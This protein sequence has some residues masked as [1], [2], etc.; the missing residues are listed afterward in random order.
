MNSTYSGFYSGTDNTII[1]AAAIPN[2]D[3][4][5]NLNLFHHIINSDIP[6]ETKDKL[7]NICNDWA[8]DVGAC[9]I[10][11]HR[12]REK[13]AGEDKFI[14]SSMCK[15][16][17]E[18]FVNYIIEEFYELGKMIEKRNPN[19]NTIMQIYNILFLIADGKISVNDARRFFK[20]IK[21]G[22]SFPTALKIVLESSG[23]KLNNYCNNFDSRFIFYIIVCTC[24][25][26]YIIYK[27]VF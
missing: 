13:F 22:M 27:N 3:A 12:H 19:P 21:L 15:L 10:N 9:K 5:C 6:D 26:F 1:G 25:I 8:N 16:G 14:L 17:D 2:D 24:L 11:L 18:K 23:I 20:N 7:R 4:V